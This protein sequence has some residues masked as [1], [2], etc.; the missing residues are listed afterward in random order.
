MKVW[1]REIRS[2]SDA[3]NADCKHVCMF[4][5][6]DADQAGTVTGSTAESLIRVWSYSAVPPSVPFVLESGL[7]NVFK[8][9]DNVVEG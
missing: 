5:K 3:V 4:Y 8:G 2:I 9:E 1:F 7:A 6:I